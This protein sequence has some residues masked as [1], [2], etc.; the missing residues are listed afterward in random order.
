V[1]YKPIYKNIFYEKPYGKQSLESAE[2]FYKAD[3]SLPCHQSMSDEDVEY[4]IKAVFEVFQEHKY[5]YRY[6][7]RSF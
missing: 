3:I 5:R 1:H 4:V 7:Y 6:R 2:E